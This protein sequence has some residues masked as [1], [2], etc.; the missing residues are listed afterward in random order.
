[1]A[2]W[3]PE[4]EVRR[5]EDAAVSLEGSHIVDTQQEGHLQEEWVSEE[6]EAS[7][8]TDQI[9]HLSVEPRIL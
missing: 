9:S 6:G 5:K 4:L 8:L 3:N 1:L 7:M 2:D